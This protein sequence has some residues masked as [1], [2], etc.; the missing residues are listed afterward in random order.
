MLNITKN[1]PLYCIIRHDEVPTDPL[2]E[3]QIVFNS[4]FTGTRYKLDNT[5]VH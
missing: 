1:V 2:E 4:S 3:E 5:K